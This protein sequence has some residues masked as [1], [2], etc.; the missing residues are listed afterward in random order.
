MNTR[1]GKYEQKTIE[2]C[3]FKGIEISSI[4]HRRNELS[5]QLLGEICRCIR[6]TVCAY[7]M[8]SSCIHLIISHF[9]FH[10]RVFILILSVPTHC[11]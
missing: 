9:G 7:C 11:I 1:W 2:N 6:L 10:S 5:E 3:H 8:P 4:L